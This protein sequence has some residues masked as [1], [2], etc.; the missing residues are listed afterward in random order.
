[1]TEEPDWT[2]LDSLAREVR[3][4]ETPGEAMLL[5]G[6]WGWRKGWRPRAQYEVAGHRVDIA[7]LEAR[8]AIE[9]DGFDHHSSNADLERD[10]AQQNAIVAAGW[11]PLRYTAQQ[12]FLTS[13]QSATAAL[14]EINRRLKGGP[15]L[16]MRP[17]PTPRGLPDLTEEQRAALV[18]GAKALLATLR[19]EE[20]GGIVQRRR[21]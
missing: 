1:M 4:T 16:Q 11:T 13:G 21:R 18:D 20:T 5:C 10:H 7:V 15:Q 2:D 9:S 6:I 12:S 3:K 8:V 14:R 19:S 17:S